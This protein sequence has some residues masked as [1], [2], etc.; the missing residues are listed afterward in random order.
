MK[1]TWRAAQEMLRL[2]PP[3]FGTFRTALK[4]IEFNGYLIP[5]GWKVLWTGGRLF[6]AF[7]DW[8]SSNRRSELRPRRHRR[9]RRRP[10]SPPC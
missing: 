2:V 7:C 9:L 3:I 1:F 6:I 10:P 8:N 5:K 4:D